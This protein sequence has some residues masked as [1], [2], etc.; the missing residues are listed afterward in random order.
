MRSSPLSVLEHN[1][2]T[3]PSVPLDLRNSLP[4]CAGIY[5]AIFRSQ[6]LYI[7]RSRNIKARW[8]NHHRI[9]DLSAVSGV[10]LAWLPFD[11]S[12]GELH[13]IERAFI[14]AYLPVLNDGPVFYS[15]D[16]GLVK[17]KRSRPDSWETKH[18]PVRGSFTYLCR[19][20]INDLAGR[21]RLLA[22]IGHG[23]WFPDWIVTL[24][25]GPD[26][27][28]F[29]LDSEWQKAKA[30]QVRL[31]VSWVEGVKATAE[32]NDLPIEEVLARI[33]NGSLKP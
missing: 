21:H 8:R 26:P 11:V 14:D 13:L 29:E 19:F 27:E 33:A 30:A 31:W 3:L 6:V 23:A 22:P 7:G 24:M 12:K 9:A 10:L 4:A 28:A 18:D 1:P 25:I 15:P 2:L 5:F 32:S 16:D 20:V 17:P